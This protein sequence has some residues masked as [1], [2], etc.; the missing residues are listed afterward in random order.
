MSSNLSSRFHQFKINVTKAN[1]HSIY[2]FDDFR[3]EIDKLMLYRSE[4]PTSLPPRAVEILAVLVKNRGEIISKDALIDA[5]WHDS[6]VEES[7]LTQHLYLI[8]KTLAARQGGKPYIET[9]RK[10]GYRFDCDTFDVETARPFEPAEES[11]MA[12]EMPPGDAHES[13]PFP[14]AAPGLQVRPSDGWSLRQVTLVTAVPAF[15][16]VVILGFLVWSTLFAGDKISVPS[17]LNLTRLTNGIE[18]QDTAISPDGKYFAYHELDGPRSRI[19]VQQTGQPN[20]VEIVPW[21]DRWHSSKTFSP[22][23]N[24]I[25]FLEF[26]EATGNNLIRVPSLGGQQVKI[27][28]GIGSSISFSPEGDEFAFYRYNAQERSSQIV[29]R[30]TDGTGQ[31]R[32]VYSRKD[33]GSGT[34]VAWS[35]DGHTIA[36]TSWSASRNEGECS[37]EKI[38]LL[39]GKVVRF[40]DESFYTCYSIAWHPDGQGLYAIATKSGDGY[41]TRRDQLYFLSLA[42]RRSIRLTFD[43]SRLQP[44]SLGVTRDNSVL[45]VPFNRSSQIWAMNANGDSRTAVQLTSGLSDGRPGIAPLADGRVAYVARA[46]ENLGVWI[47]NP[48]GSGQTQMTTEPEYLEELRAS[49]DGRYLV[50]S[51]PSPDGKTNHLFRIDSDGTGQIQFTFQSHVIDSGTS[52]DGLWVAY[53][54]EI[55]SGNTSRLE[56][57]KRPIDGGDPVRLKVENCSRPH[58]SPDD[59]YLSCIG[60]DERIFIVSAKD[61]AIVRSFSALPRSTLSFGSRWSPDGKSV[62]YIAT[63]KDVSNLWLQ[64][65]DGSRPRRLTNF[66]AGSIYHFAY[67]RDFRTLYL[68]RGTQIRDA[69][70]I[71]DSAR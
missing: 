30:P 4:L 27:L 6:V 36:F 7:N 24:Y 58:F 64:P 67:S 29:I 55:F 46:G 40:W 31:E 12:A 62:T 68:A 3:L 63:E 15:F 14:V 41:S 38:D 54:D 50:Y 13:L 60:K 57:W 53:A 42:D 44:N 35:P 25:Y 23:G 33:D 22:D 65:V 52:H 69:I 61:G 28:S 2:R 34:Y 45:V 19:W 32:V 71:S 43:G 39:D 56:L 37:I 26:D 17:E 66:T 48:D 20:R 11:L 59:R 5:V 16:G 9:L 1:G 21:G 10:R 70:L 8:R 47:M 49:G 51:A 18:V